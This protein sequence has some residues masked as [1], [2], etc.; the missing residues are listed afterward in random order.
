[1]QTSKQFFVS[2]FTTNNILPNRV[3]SKTSMKCLYWIKKKEPFMQKQYYSTLKRSYTKISDPVQYQV[4]KFTTIHLMI[5]MSW[6]RYLSFRHEPDA[7]LGSPLQFDR[8]LF[9]VRND[10]NGIKKSK[11]SFVLLT[12]GKIKIKSNEVDPQSTRSSSKI[13]SF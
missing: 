7:I 13:S 5:Q 4:L 3:N 1:M 12:V 2:S 10:S 6:W 8:L 9:F 11:V